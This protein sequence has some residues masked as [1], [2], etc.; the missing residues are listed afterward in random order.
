MTDYLR[1]FVQRLADTFTDLKTPNPFDGLFVG[2]NKSFWHKNAVTGNDYTGVERIMLAYHKM[3]MG[4]TDSLWLTECEADELGIRLR[5][6]S[7]PIVLSATIHLFNTNQCVEED[8][9]LLPKLHYTVHSYEQVMA[10]IPVSL[11][12]VH[13][14]YACYYP[15]SDE[16]NLPNISHVF[17]VEATKTTMLHEL[18]HATGHEKR[19]ARNLH[20]NKLGQANYAREELIAEIGAVILCSVLGISRGMQRTAFY[21][22]NSLK[23]LN[24]D[25]DILHDAILEAEKGCQYI[26]NGWNGEEAVVSHEI[27]AQYFD[28]L[29]A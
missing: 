13:K 20:L 17:T 19:L 12:H 14:K 3:E 22:Q 15:L 5:D 2:R 10:N 4:F 28:A 24:Y 26:L 8:L 16:I 21:I 6:D 18:V 25:T 29:Y 1:L 27:V 9:I 23:V 11:I 7:K